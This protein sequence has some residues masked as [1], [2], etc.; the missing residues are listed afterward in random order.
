MGRSGRSCP[1]VSLLV[2]VAGLS[3]ALW[4]VQSELCVRPHTRASRLPSLDGEKVMLCFM[5]LWSRACISTYFV[6]FQMYSSSTGKVSL[7][8][9]KLQIVLKGPSLV[10][11]AATQNTFKAI[12]KTHCADY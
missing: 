4:W 2:L 11:Y 6:F 12:H 5:A 7:N 10:C 9:F 1:R 3:L 8:H